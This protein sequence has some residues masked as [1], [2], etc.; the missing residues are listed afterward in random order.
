MTNC[1]ESN[2]K[3]GVNR[4]VLVDGQELQ[5]GYPPGIYDVQGTRASVTVR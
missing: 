4:P 1:A 2:L 5:F 3:T